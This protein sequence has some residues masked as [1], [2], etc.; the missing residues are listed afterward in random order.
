MTALNHR[1]QQTIIDADGRYLS[2]DELLPLENY[3]GTYP[4]RLEAYQEIS[5]KSNELVLAALRKFARVHPE[6][7]QHSGKRCQ[8]D[9]S[10]VLQYMA[11]ALLLDDEFMFREK[12]MFWLDTMLR[13]HH[14]QEACSKAYHHLQEA[15]QS[16]LTANTTELVRPLINIVFESLQS[17]T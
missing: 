12:M 7:I 2:G 10:Q 13:A 16:N 14:K 3:L 15:I 8:F 5:Q 9:M 6:I 1:L 17:Y 11:L 4:R